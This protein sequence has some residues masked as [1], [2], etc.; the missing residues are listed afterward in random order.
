[1]SRLKIQKLQLSGCY[2][3]KIKHAD[4]QEDMLLTCSC[5]KEAAAFTA[6]K[7][8]KAI[9]TTWAGRRIFPKALLP[10]AA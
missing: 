6:D 7:N 9:S 4:P 10:K 3:K 5:V 1:M 8:F 2:G